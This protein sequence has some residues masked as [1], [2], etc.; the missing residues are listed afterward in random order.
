M[1]SK[2]SF[3]VTLDRTAARP[4]NA[5]Q[6]LSVCDIVVESGCG[7]GGRIKGQHPDED[8]GVVYLDKPGEVF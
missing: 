3:K 4:L 7:G 8:A 5:P 1:R 6:A 2:K